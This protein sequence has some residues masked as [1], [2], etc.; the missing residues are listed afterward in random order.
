[1]IN[2]ERVRDPNEAWRLIFGGLGAATRQL[3][4]QN[5]AR[6]GVI[7]GVKGTLA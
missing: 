1:V 2:W 3:L 6:R 5:R 4:T 7:A